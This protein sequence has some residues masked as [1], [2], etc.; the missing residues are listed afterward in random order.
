MATF[1][2]S[3]TAPVEVP[4]VEPSVSDWPTSCFEE[5]SA[6]GSW[7]TMNEI[8]ASSRGPLGPAT[9]KAPF[10]RGR[11]IPGEGMSTDRQR[12]NIRCATALR[13]APRIPV[14]ICPV[15]QRRLAVPRTS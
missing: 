6:L 10:A 12:I 9:R 8:C 2:A 1:W 14:V 11:I 4:Q 3:G 13:H 5:S 7:N 15:F